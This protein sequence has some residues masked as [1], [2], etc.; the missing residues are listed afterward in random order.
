MNKDLDN[1]KPACYVPWV[2]R[3]DWGNGDITPCC[4][5]DP[6]TK[7]KTTE[8]MSLEDSFNHPKMKA[9]RTQL[10]TCDKNDIDALPTGCNQ[11]KVFEKAGMKDSMR[12]AVT[13]VVERAEQNSSYKFN[14]DEFKLLWLDYR[15]SNLCNFS[16]KMCGEDLSSTH[17]KIQGKYGKTGIIKSPHKLQMYLD[18]LDEVKYVQFLGGEPVLT[19]S[20]YIIL[21]EIKKR[22]LQHQICMNITT[23]GSL[24]HKDNDSLL[25]L[26]KGFDAVQIAISIDCMGDQHNYWRHKGTWNIVWKNTREIEKW[27]HSQDGANMKIRTAIGW[28]NAYAARKTFDIF[29][30]KL[31]NGKVIHVWNLVN[32]PRGLSLT[33]LPQDRLDDLS[34]WW[35][36]YP[37]VA[38]MFKNTISK[39]NIRELMWVKKDIFKKH[40][41][42]HGNSFVKAFPEFEDFYNNIEDM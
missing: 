39:P 9:L 27:V 13:D 10:L 26:C 12:L 17:A 18:R 2:T 22:N 24:L 11:C 34:V 40:D 6:N 4:E 42:W 7:I 29:A 1:K 5:F 41:A 16:C 8:N 38:K 31:G 23:N 3:Y 19:D 15:E 35:K 28:P 30:D 32:I 20:M 21:K 36:D 25:E 37:D 33:Q 14:P